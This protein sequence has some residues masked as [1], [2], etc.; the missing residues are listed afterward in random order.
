MQQAIQPFTLEVQ[1]EFHQWIH[2]SEHTNRAR[3]APEKHSLLLMFLHT[4][5][6]IKLKQIS[7]LRFMAIG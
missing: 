7:E 1:A 3:M 5:E 4:S 6:I 2:R